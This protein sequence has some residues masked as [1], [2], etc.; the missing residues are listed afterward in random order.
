MSAPL[1]YFGVTIILGGAVEMPWIPSSKFCTAVHSLA[2][3]V[4]CSAEIAGTPTK[5]APKRRERIEA[6]TFVIKINTGL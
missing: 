3:S 6:R 1:V 5:E 4:G 2:E